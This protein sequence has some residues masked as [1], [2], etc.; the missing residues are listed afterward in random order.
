MEP[1]STTPAIEP[2]GNPDLHQ[3]TRD[4]Q[5]QKEEQL[6]GYGHVLIDTQPHEVHTD[7][8][9]VVLTPR[10]VSAVAHG[11]TDAK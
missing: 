3:Q 7:A 5:A 9:G 4:I 8:N 2:H 10:E 6:K 11:E 1:E